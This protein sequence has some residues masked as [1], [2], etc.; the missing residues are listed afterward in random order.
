M[1]NYK[2]R[3]HK[4]K[5]FVF[6]VDGV[7][8]DGSIISTLDGDLLRVFDSKDGF[9][10]RMAI[11]NGFKIGIITGGNSDSILKRFLALS[12]PEEDIYQLSRDK[13]PDFYDFCSKHQLSPE[14]VAYVGDDIPDI[15][16]LKICG[17]AA[18]PSDAVV[19]VKEVCDYISTH[20]GGKGCARELIEQVLKVQEKWVFNVNHF[21]GKY[22]HFGR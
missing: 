15:P 13:A 4:I 9:G 20:G 17:L 10:M 8:T 6:D 7:L 18:C 11:M 14:E 1:G 3:L 5:A 2:N 21:S 22:G 12:I 16:V 19:E